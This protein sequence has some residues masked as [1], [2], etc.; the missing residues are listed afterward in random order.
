MSNKKR[1]VQVI[2]NSIK[3]TNQSV[4]VKKREHLLY[5]MNA[6]SLS[7]DNKSNIRD[8]DM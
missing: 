4:R 2:F 1:I 8:H 6:Y 3:T 7:S 5:Q